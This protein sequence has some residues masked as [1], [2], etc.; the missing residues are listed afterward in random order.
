MF[1]KIILLISSLFTTFVASKT[2][3]TIIDDTNGDEQTKI[4]PVYFP[5]SV[6]DDNTCG[7]ERCAIIPDPA[8]AYQG[9]WS[10][11]TY[12]PGR[13]AGDEISVS[14]QFQGTGISVFLI[15]VNHL[16]QTGLTTLSQCNFTLDGQ[17]QKEY[18]YTP[19]SEPGLKY[20]EEAFNI[21]GLAN[22]SHSLKMS[23][24]GLDH[25]VYLNFDYAN[26]TY[27]ILDPSSGSAPSSST[28]TGAI[29]GGAVGGMFVVIAFVVF[30]VYRRKRRTHAITSSH[31]ATTSKHAQHHSLPRILSEENGLSAPHGH[32]QPV[33]PYPTPLNGGHIQLPGVSLP[34]M[35]ERLFIK[36]LETSQGTEREELQ[37]RAMSLR[38]ELRHL[39][40]QT[41]SSVTFLQSSDLAVEELR[42]EVRSM[43]EQLD[44]FRRQHGPPPPGYTSCIAPSTV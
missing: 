9:T 39:E 1:T 17:L 26:Y 7:P 20:G 8:L 23:V 21:S 36:Q 28:L 37:S 31:T 3:Y 41:Q 40:T 13:V 10:A 14:L 6:W 4:K 29:V 27:E 43:Q 18:V 42:E 24:G 32:T 19:D 11:A 34:Q 35:P 33:Q 16:E 12:R 22:T 5:T 30:F 2:F 15:V 44:I 25:E 38:D